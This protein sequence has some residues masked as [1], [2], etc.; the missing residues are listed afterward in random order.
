MKHKH[1]VVKTEVTETV[2]KEKT[3]E[4]K[5][6]EFIQNLNKAKI[7]AARKIVE[8]LNDRELIDIVF[9]EQIRSVQLDVISAVNAIL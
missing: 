2:A 4:D 9:Y 5:K 8:I 1:E 3:E 7:E 6:I